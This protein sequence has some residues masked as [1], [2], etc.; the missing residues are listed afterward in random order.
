M[1]LTKT[2]KCAPF[3]L[4]L[5]LVLLN[6]TLNAQEREKFNGAYSIGG[7]TG[8][9]QLEYLTIAADTI[10]DGAF[11]LEDANAK[12]IFEKS[13]ETFVFDGSF[14]RNVPSGKWSI[15][16]GKFE[17][18]DAATFSDFKYQVDLSGTLKEMT[19]ELQSGTLA[20]PWTFS[21][22]RIKD[23]KVLDTLIYSSYYFEKGWPRQ[24]FEI[25][26][27]DAAMTGRLLQNG[28]A[29]DTWSAFS[30]GH[31]DEEHWYFDNGR[32][33]KIERTALQGSTTD[34]V[35]SKSFES[36]TTLTWG[37]AYSKLIDIYSN[38]KTKISDKGTI[39]QLLT[40]SYGQYDLLLKTLEKL[41]MPKRDRGMRFTVPMVPLK[42]STKQA[43]IDRTR[44][45]QRM[46]DV[47]EAMLNSTQLNL[48][49]RA[50][51]RVADLLEIAQVIDNEFITP[52]REFVEI[53]DLDIVHHVEEA[54][55]VGYLF[56][57]GTPSTKL[58]AKEGQLDFGV[59][60]NAELDFPSNSF[61]TLF[62]ITAFAENAI[63]QL[64]KELRQ[65]LEDED[66]RQEFILLEK[67]M[68][69]LSDHITQFTD[70]V[71][72]NLDPLV[73]RSLVNLN[74]AVE[75]LIQEYTAMPAGPSKLVY[76]K[77]FVDCL[78]NAKTMSKEIGFLSKNTMAVRAHYKDDVWN[79]FTATIMKANIKKRIVN[80]YVD[81][82]VPFL[83]ESSTPELDCQDLQELADAFMGLNRR[84]FE[85][86]DEET[87]K[88]ERKLRK[89]RNA[90]TVLQLFDLKPLTIQ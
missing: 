4:P 49:K 50:D 35:F 40:Q 37:K 33:V 13:N 19:G 5:F 15:Q 83:L 75:R 90:N 28:R 85:L 62:Q 81:V 46:A 57:N 52:L 48:I 64:E 3:W 2:T 68:V 6:Y 1:N 70:S 47:S 18:S 44:T 38:N 53:I 34:E 9:A 74:S 17:G 11:K 63:D 22:K 31:I 82:A 71:K 14:T 88:L 29:H 23:S 32:L 73:Q 16:F 54:Q 80:A 76:A 30:N 10:L 77:Q 8:E 67:Q 60:E 79:P 55:L 25:S 45:I 59:F 89:V 20:G 12:T 7:F 24:S 43:L 65:K 84:M 86:R 42:V 39:N 61:E 69:A 56:P 36:D 51:K 72:P 27:G 66:E 41:G 78:E 87:T 21:N 26:T 58:V